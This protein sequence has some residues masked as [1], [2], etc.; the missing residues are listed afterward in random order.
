MRHGL[1]QMG[2]G[3]ECFIKQELPVTGRCG[4][5]Y[6][7]LC[8]GLFIFIIHIK[9]RLLCHIQGIALIGSIEG[10]Y[11]LLLLVHQ[12]QLGSGGAGVDAQINP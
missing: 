7:K 2:L 5:Y 12:Y 8:S 11:Q 3:T 6:L 9:E 10:I 4:S 1:H